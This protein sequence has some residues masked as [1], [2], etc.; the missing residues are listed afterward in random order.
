MRPWGKIIVALDGKTLQETAAFINHLNEGAQHVVYKIG[1]GLIERYGTE[2]LLDRLPSGAYFFDGKQDDIPETCALSS[3]AYTIGQHV[4][5]LSDRQVAMVTV[6]ASAGRAAM[7]RVRETVAAHTLVLGVTVLTSLS[8]EECV[9]IYGKPPLAKVVEFALDAQR[10][11]LDG[12]I[13]S[14]LE[15]AA[16]R[17]ACQA[18]FLIVTPGIRLAGDAV[19]DQQRHA[20]PRMAA[21]NGANHL[22]VGR[23]ITAAEDPAEALRRIQAEFDLGINDR[24][25]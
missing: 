22:V 10:A 13:C 24:I 3:A 15:I 4:S 11:G 6:M 21:M 17:R 9:S 25:Y 16:V 14:P 18:D 1:R 8:R 23:P 12:V 19:N 2:S 7:C 20:T 5:R